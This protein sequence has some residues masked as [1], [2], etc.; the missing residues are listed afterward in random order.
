M[1]GNTTTDRLATR[2]ERESEIVSLI[3]QSSGP[4]KKTS[5]SSLMSSVQSEDV[6]EG[7]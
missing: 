5:M 3:Q 6:E 4:E 2:G 1:G 7:K